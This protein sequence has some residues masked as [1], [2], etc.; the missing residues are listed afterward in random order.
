MSQ[1]EDI[2][3]EFKTIRIPAYIYYKLAELTGLIGIIRG[4]SASI[5]D[6]TS[7]LVERFYPFLYPYFLNII[8]NPKELQKFRD[9]LSNNKELFELV[10]GIKI[11]E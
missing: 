6:T 10:K 7:N 11:K 3:P 5:S 8:N 1:N 9:E 4:E 2:K